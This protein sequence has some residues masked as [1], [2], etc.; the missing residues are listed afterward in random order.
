MKDPLEDV[1]VIVTVRDKKES[2]KLCDIIKA[3]G[4][5]DVSAAENTLEMVLMALKNDRVVLIAETGNNMLDLSAA[6]DYVTKHCRYATISV[7]VDAW[8][9]ELNSDLAGAVDVFLTRPVTERELIPGLMLDAA[10]KKHMQELEAELRESEESFAK[11][12][13]MSFA[14]HVVMD[15]LGLSKEGAGEYILSLAG[16]HGYDEGD[17]AR[18]V[19]EV[20]LAGGRK[21]Q[22]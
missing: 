7:I 12:K 19:Y 8:T 17:A 18:I 6:L 9:D 10:R 3:S 1:K 11:D 16:K 13:N 4:A 2:R 21:K 14:E 22:L 5:A 15:T 20:L